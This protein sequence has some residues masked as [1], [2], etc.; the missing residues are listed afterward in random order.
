MSMALQA[1]AV[2]SILLGLFIF[3]VLIRTQIKERLNEFNLLKILGTETLIIKK[4]IF[5][6]FLFVTSISLL[7]GL[8]LGLII[9]ALLIFFVFGTVSEFDYL[10]MI[11]VTSVLMPITYI[12]I[13]FSTRFLDQLSPL[14]LIRSD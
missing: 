7:I 9:S 8:L 1:M 13:Y 10:S 6:Q 14:S 2:I 12:I 5:K 3:V 11:L 4:I